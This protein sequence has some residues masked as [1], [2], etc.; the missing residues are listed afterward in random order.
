MNG[1]KFVSL[2]NRPTNNYFLY[3]VYIR[4]LISIKSTIPTDKLGEFAMKINQNCVGCGQCVAFC[5][6][7]AIHVWGRAEITE[8]CVDCKICAYYCPLKAIEVTE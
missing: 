1:L 7:N 5:K 4:Y 2:I 8:D 3:Q 6:K